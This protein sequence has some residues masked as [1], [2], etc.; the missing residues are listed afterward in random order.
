MGEAY[1]ILRTR[2]SRRLFV[3]KEYQHLIY[4]KCPPFLEHDLEFS[5]VTDD[6]KDI[7]M[8]D[9]Y[10]FWKHMVYA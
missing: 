3:E 7:E 5:K 9:E 1:L 6:P 2:N 8:N 10:K 4:G